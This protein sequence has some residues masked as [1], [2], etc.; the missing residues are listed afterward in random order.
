M[1]LFSLLH[2]GQARIYRGLQVSL[3]RRIEREQERNENW[4]MPEDMRFELAAIDA[5]L[6][7]ASA[8]VTKIHD[9]SAKIDASTST[10]QLEAQLRAEFVAAAKTITESEWAILDEV[11]ARTQLQVQS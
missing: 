9:T 2:R 8:A 3:L 1:Q 11:R 4:E 6:A 10:E 5:F 7:K